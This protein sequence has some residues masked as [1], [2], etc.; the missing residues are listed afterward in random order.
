[1][2]SDDLLRRRA[3][4]QKDIDA[5]LTKIKKVEAE[6][7]RIIGVLD[8]T[9]E[10][11][12]DIDRDFEEKTKLSKQDVSILFF[13]VALQVA[14]QYL[15]KKLF[16]RQD[17]QTAA[18]D[19]LLYEKKEKK[20][21]YNRSHHLYN[22]TYE[23]I[24]KAP[25]PF[26]A[27]VGAHG[28]LSGGGKLGHRVK[29][30]GH[31]PIL[32]LIV[33][34]ANIATS[35]LTT[36]DLKSFHIT[37]VGKIDVFGQK[38]RTDLVFYYTAQKLLYQGIEGKKI[39]GLSLWKEVQHLNSDIL[40]KNSL[41]LPAVSLY[42]PKLSSSLASYGLDMANVLKVSSQVE[43]ATMINSFIA[44]F[45]FLFCDA[46]TPKERKLYEVRTRKILTYSNLIAST[47]NVIYVAITKD[48]KSLD[49]GG[50]LVTLYRLVTDVKFIR[51]IKREF[52]FGSYRDLIMNPTNE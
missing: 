20:R 42:D 26:D 24:D 38:A 44:M 23:E 15:L 29:T 37:K 35:T 52:I 27:N 6:T 50:L 16:E 11:L 14:R 18:K 46:E 4:L 19:S 3:G 33:G 45:H 34:T 12:E 8:H 7:E 25:V 31:D 21:E 41:P 39:I 30:L 48:F 9:S 2:S 5:S 10:I 13:A 40:S 36:S 1:M 22:P 47:S 49:I 17:D 32:G 28:A 51:Q 43:F